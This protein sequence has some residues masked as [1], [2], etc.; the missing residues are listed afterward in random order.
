MKERFYEVFINN[1]FKIATATGIIIGFL[2][3][4][5]PFLLPLV[6][7]G[8]LALAMSPFVSAFMHKYTW[9]KAKT[10]SII[11]LVMFFVVA[12]PV[13]IFFLRGARIISE[14]I[15]KKSLANVT[16]AIQTK[17]YALLDL[18][19]TTSH[20][21]NEM[22]KVKFNGFIN[23]AAEFVLGI[24]SNMLKQIPDLLLGLVVIIFSFY[25]L[26]LKEDN[27][28]DFFDKFYSFSNRQSS[29]RFIKILKSS[30]RE[31]FLVNVITGILQS[32]I[33]SLGA[34]AC[35]IG[36]FYIVF[37]FTFIFSFI[38][39][40]GAGPMAALLAL[41]AFGDA[42]IGAG[43]TM[44]VISVVAGIADN[45]IRP[46]LVSLGEVE[47]PAYIGFLAVIGGVIVL[48]LPGLFVGP[49]LASLLYG[50]VPI[51]LD[52]YLPNSTN[53]EVKVGDVES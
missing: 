29:N 33:V 47:V 50:A 32:S 34:L 48:G 53:T 44:V 45:L 4:L 6:F 42:R 31:V 7:G 36:D 46:Y 51:I 41:M 20:L 5:S 37:F 18:F 15:S 12:V 52:E 49:L 8:I 21:D 25:F 14:F 35:G 40:I 38:P 9:S 39:V 2:Y 28:R 3:I 26:L 11:S 19:A 30:C 24:F 16:E 22:I 43:I 13:T 10:L 27:I 23:N 1:F 17:I